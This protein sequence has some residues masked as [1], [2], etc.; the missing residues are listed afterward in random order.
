MYTPG[1]LIYF[2][3]FY[4]KDGSESKP[5]YFLVLKVIGDSAILASLPSSV[6]H[7]PRNLQINHGC[8]EI[9]EGNINCYVF[10]SNLPITKN[11]WSFK[12]DTFLYGQWID[13]F[14]ISLLQ[15]IYPVEEIDYKIIGELTDL[16]LKSV[17]DCF[18]K[19]ATVK[20]KY[21]RM[22]S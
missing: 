6:D 8:I 7:L 10:K 22:L 1:N 21:K 14:S 19:S 2:D 4:F 20:R 11:D 9:P 17:I 18:A 15:D 5:K 16:E 12:F 13:D 3:P